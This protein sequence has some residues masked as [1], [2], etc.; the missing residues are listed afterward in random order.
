MK[1]FKTELEKLKTR[2][3]RLYNELE[4]L[5]DLDCGAALAE[6]M[7]PRIREA[8]EEFALVWKRIKELDP[9]SPENPFE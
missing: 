9:E 4:D 6:E 5:Y 2:A 3:A 1:I 8:K 7:R